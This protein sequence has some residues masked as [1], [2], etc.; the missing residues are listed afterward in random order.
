MCEESIKNILVQIEEKTPKSPDEVGPEVV[1][2]LL[3]ELSG[4]ISRVNG[5][6][7][8]FHTDTPIVVLHALGKVRNYTSHLHT[9]DYRK[10]RLVHLNN[11]LT[12]RMNT[13]SEK[14]AQN[15]QIPAAGD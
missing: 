7:L 4:T 5:R 13:I 11:I 1:L 6:L 8:G 12:N 3:Q 14:T 2:H 10:E 9:N 15:V